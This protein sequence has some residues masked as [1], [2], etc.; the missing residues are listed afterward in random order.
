MATSMTVGWRERDPL[1]FTMGGCITEPAVTFRVILRNRRVD[2]M[3]RRARGE[4][5]GFRLL[6]LRASL[7]DQSRLGASGSARVLKGGLFP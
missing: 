5:D 2:E 6:Q 4:A 7:S 1:T 3:E